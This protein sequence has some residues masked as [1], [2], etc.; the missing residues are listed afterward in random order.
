VN[1]IDGKRTVS[2]IRNALSAEFGPLPTTAVARYVED[3]V[4]VGVVE[5]AGTGERE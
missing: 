2:D 5:W 4:E 3:L 1:F